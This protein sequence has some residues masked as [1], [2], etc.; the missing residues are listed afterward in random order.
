MLRA[1][2]LQ[3]KGNWDTHSSLMEFAYNN[4][5]QSSMGMA[6]FEALYGRPCRTPVC[7]NEVGERKLVGH[8]LVQV[9]SDNI[10]L[11]RENLKI[12]KDRQK[13]Y[14][15]KQ[16]RDL[17]FQIGEQVFLKLSP[18]RGVLRFGRKDPSHVLQ[19]QPIELKDDLIY[20]DEAIQIL[21]RKEQSTGFSSK[22]GGFLVFSDALS[23]LEVH[24]SNQKLYLIWPRENRP[25]LQTGELDKTLSIDY[26]TEILSLRPYGTVC[27]QVIFPL[28][29]LSVLR[30][31]DAVVEI[32]LPVPDTLPSSTESFESNSSTWLELYFEF[33][34]VE[35]FCYFTNQVMSGLH[36][37]YVGKDQQGSL[38]ETMSVGFTSSFGLRQQ[39]GKR[40]TLAVGDR[41]MK[42]LRTDLSLNSEFEVRPS[43]RERASNLVYVHSVLE[44]K[45]S[46]E[47]PLR[48]RGHDQLN[49]SSDLAKGLELLLPPLRAGNAARYS[50]FKFG[51]LL[52]LIDSKDHNKEFPYSQI[53]LDQTLP[54]YARTSLSLSVALFGGSFLSRDV[55][56]EEEVVEHRTLTSLIQSSREFSLFSRS[57][58]LSQAAFAPLLRFDEWG[59]NP[60]SHSNTP[61]GSC[62]HGDRSVLL[63]LSADPLMK[64]TTRFH[65][66]FHW[67]TRVNQGKQRIFSHDTWEDRKEDLLG[68]PENRLLGN[69]NRAKAQTPSQYQPIGAGE[70]TSRYSSLDRF[71]RAPHNH[72]TRFLEG[73]NQSR[74]G[75]E[76]P[77]NLHSM[78]PLSPSLVRGSDTGKD[79]WKS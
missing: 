54:A 55:S 66:P 47:T 19:V 27:T 50:F 7:W 45:R 62:G 61:P 38:E 44:G 17:E 42:L 41:R 21:D 79:R 28:S 60:F 53:V 36:L 13:S 34:H 3:F 25:S 67:T 1:C 51:M 14:A 70:V 5:Y 59:G 6:P 49:Q 78:I 33:V 8:E 64:P 68:D 23:I 11:I 26:M 77:G 48:G 57:S 2:V 18:W 74:S 29:T 39:V 37:M 16:R 4:S 10:K 32:E 24:K 76:S 73:M 35:M 40:G 52:R 15:D 72:Y 46:H 56:T 20:R 71:H 31:N 30:D 12:A 65:S 22:P 58:P 43:V 69:R 9:T 75:S 63:H